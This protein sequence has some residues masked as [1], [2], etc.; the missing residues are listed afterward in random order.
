MDCSHV[1]ELLPGY[2]LNAL[3]A[4]EAAG[5]E[6]HLDSCVSCTAALR[7]QVESVT[8]LSQAAVLSAP[9]DRLK[10]RLL[11]RIPSP[12]RREA[13][14]AGAFAQRFSFGY[15]ALGAA[16][17]VMIVALAAFIGVAIGMSNK[18]GGLERENG[19]L[20]ARI[21]EMGDMDDKLVE[22]TEEQRFIS[23]AMADPHS[24][25]VPLTVAQES[26]SAKAL[27]L[28]SHQDGV[29]IL[30]A[31]GL[32]PPAPGG[33]YDVWLRSDDRQYRMGSLAVDETG[34]GI[35]TIAPE[36]PM[37]NFQD[38]LV[39]H[40]TSTQT[41]SSDGAAPVLWGTLNEG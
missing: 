26:P 1:E 22:M 18:I 29:G 40:R 31:F 9:P 27:L 37:A 11:A 39:T 7:D 5:V 4:A 25:V 24:E 32:T 3:D 13:E 6:E 16:A 38:I 20:T 2:A 21:D 10:S 23:Y 35:L 14:P 28:V 15:I 30:M 12:P 8:L 34:W 41:S 33:Q 19:Q 36:K 17:S